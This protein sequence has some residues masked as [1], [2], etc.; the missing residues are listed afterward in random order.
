[1]NINDL[2]SFGEDEKKEI[3]GFLSEFTE[4]TNTLSKDIANALMEASKDEDFRVP[5]TMWVNKTADPDKYELVVNDIHLSDMIRKFSDTY[6]GQERTGIII[7]IYLLWLEKTEPD[8]RGICFFVAELCHAEP[9]IADGTELCYEAELFEDGWWFISRELSLEDA[10]G[11]KIE[12]SVNEYDTWQVLLHN[13][14]LFTA[15]AIDFKVGT[16]LILS[17]KEEAYIVY[18]P[19]EE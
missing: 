18:A 17:D 7:S 16:R 15:L 5:L 10:D 8:L 1:M 4:K 11:E 3:E 12:S 6:P 9:C 14:M 2:L 19:V 13:P